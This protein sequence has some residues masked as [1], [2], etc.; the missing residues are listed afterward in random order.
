MCSYYL[1]IVAGLS[2]PVAL[3]RNFV[4]CLIDW[5]KKVYTATK[6]QE[7][8]DLGQERGRFNLL[9]LERIGEVSLSSIPE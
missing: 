8:I 5:N 7:K 4:E 1:I 2:E 6:S 9:K 3:S